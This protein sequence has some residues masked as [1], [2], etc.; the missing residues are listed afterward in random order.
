[1]KTY[2]IDCPIA[3]HQIDVD[4]LPFYIKKFEVFNISD[5]KIVRIEFNGIYKLCGVY[6]NSGIEFSIGGKDEYVHYGALGIHHL[7]VCPVV[8]SHQC[9]EIR[10]NTKPYEVLLFGFF[11]W[12]G[13]I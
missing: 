12:I 11:R 3:I 6:S 4:R 8:G 7:Q 13:E 10:F 5:N 2:D 9:L 1:M